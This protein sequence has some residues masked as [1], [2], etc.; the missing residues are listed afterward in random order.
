M[1][2]VRYIGLSALCFVGVLACTCQRQGTPDSPGSAHPSVGGNGTESPVPVTSS[3]GSSGSP[4]ADR[5][6]D[7]REISPETRLTSTQLSYQ[8]AFRLPSQFNWGARGMASHPGGAG[9]AGSLLVTGFELARRVNGEECE[10]GPD[11]LALFGELRIPTPARN[12]NWERLPM[13]DLLRPVA[14]FDG[15]R[16]RALNEYTWVSDIEIVPRRGAQTRDHLYG[17]LNLWYAEGV[18]GENTFP[19]I[20][21]SDLDGSNPQGLFHVGPERTP[22]HGRKMGDYLFRVPQWYAEEYLGGR[23]LV[24]GRARGT[25]A[26]S[27]ERQTIRGGSQGPTLF[28]FHPFETESPSGHLDA[29]PMLYYRTRFPGC[30]GPNVGDPASCDFPGYTMCDIWTGA[31]FV[32]GSA[33]RAIVLAGFKGLGNNCY[34][35]P[36]VR[37]ND[38]CSDAHGY[39]CQPYER[40]IIFYDVDEI[41]RVARGEADPWTVLPYETWRPTELFHTGH[42]CHNLGGM[43]F[44]RGGRRLFLVERGLGSADDNAAV[45]HVWTLR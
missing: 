43:T 5:T 38:P 40:Q 16:M 20:W 31:A 12:S 6:W 26:S 32:E 44:D 18:R 25:P 22:F 2:M 9:G 29:L 41:G 1:R 39:H 28:A 23:I 7:E 19:T 45:V 30:A 15:G 24:T 37:C 42:T 33:G 8:G 13:A 3:G 10:G 4:G 27:S 17:S 21:M 11:C 14:G 36:P 34:D 35:E